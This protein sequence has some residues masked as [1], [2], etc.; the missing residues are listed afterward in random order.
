MA[1][2]FQPDDKLVL[3][4]LKKVFWPETGYT[5]GDLLD[6]YRAI[7][8]VMLPYLV[9]RPQVLHRHVDGHTGKEF[10]Q[11]VSRKTPTWL[12]TTEIVLDD[13][14]VRDFHLCQDWPTLLWLANFGC[15]EFIPWSSRVGSLDR[16]DYAIIDLDPDNVPWPQVI[17]VANAVR[18]I[19]ENGAEGFCKTSGKRGMHIYI[20]LGGKY[21]FD[22]SMMVSK[23][24]A[25]LVNAKHPGITS[26]DPRTEN[27]KGL[28]YLDTTRNARGQACAAPY[29]ARPFPR[30]TVS[31]PLK[32][33]EVKK[34]LDPGNFTIKTMLARIE[35]VGDLWQGVLGPGI[36]LSG[37]VER[38]EKSHR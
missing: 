1:H 10:F 9:D 26:M 2:A 12:K 38:L 22:Q 32:W 13:G 20:P 16:P 33:S 4:N 23:L 29:S 36:D 5:K 30:A 17:E 34:G 21:T 11:R 6:Y 3:T 25:N 15:I 14:R 27:R 31:A 18:K 37:W 19:V 24:V 28:I 7:A 8:P 35:K